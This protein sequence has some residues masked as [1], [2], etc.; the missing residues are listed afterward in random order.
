MIL[1]YVSG[2]QSTSVAFADIEAGVDEYEL[3]VFDWIEHIEDFYSIVQLRVAY[4]T[5]G[6]YSTVLKYSKYDN[7]ETYYR[8]Y[9]GDYVVVENPEHSDL[10]TH[11]YYIKDW[12]NYVLVRSRTPYSSSTTYYN[13]IGFNSYEVAP[14]VKH[15][16]LITKTYYILKEEGFPLYRVCKPMDFGDYNINP[17]KNYPETGDKIKYQWGRQVGSPYIWGK[18]SEINPRYIFVPSVNNQ[19]IY[20]SHIKIFPTPIQSVERGLTLTYNFMQQPISESDAFTGNS[21]ELWTLNLPRYFFDAIEDYIT[22]RLYQAENPEMAQW[23]YQQFESTLHDNIYWLN[24]D[25]R[26]IDEGFANTTY[27]SHY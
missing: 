25:K 11:S 19:G 1:E 18:V 4:H 22:F 12:N 8:K 16:D 6:R 13:K 24:K 3:P 17:L 23:Y 2:K 27:F 7:T 15:D 14:E 10:L 21:V 9:R 20:T 26:P 5:S